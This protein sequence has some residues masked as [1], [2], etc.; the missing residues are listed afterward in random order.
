MPLILG[1]QDPIHLP[2]VWEFGLGEGGRR[3]GT[4][5]KGVY[6]ILPDERANELKLW[7]W[8]LCS[9]RDSSPCTH[10]QPLHPCSDP[11][12]GLLSI[13]LLITFL[14][15]HLWSISSTLSPSMLSMWDHKKG[16]NCPC[17][18]RATVLV[19]SEINDSPER[20]AERE[21]HMERWDSD[22]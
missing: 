10:H 6:P 1:L 7:L 15:L 19:K 5:I 3:D 17:P 12:G 21:R 8:I 18:P 4:Y 20:E 16:K 2:N 11:M 9:G 14:P 13:S 22:E